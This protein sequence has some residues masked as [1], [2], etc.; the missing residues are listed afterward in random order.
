[1]RNHFIVRYLVI[2]IV[3]SVSFLNVDA[4]SKIDANNL[5]NKLLEKDFK[6]NLPRFQ[7]SIKVNEY[8]KNVS[9]CVETR[10]DS[11]IIYA[12]QAINLAENAGLVQKIAVALQN[13]GQYYMTKEDFTNAISCFINALKI[14]EKRNDQKRIADLIDELATVYYYQEI[15]SKSLKYNENALAVYQKLKDTINIA[16]S[17]SHL[18][19]LHLSHEY[20]EQR[21]VDQK[22]ND[23]KIALK[24]FKQSLRLCEKIGNQN[25]IVHS[26]LNIGNVYNRMDQPEKALDF[27]QKALDFYRESGDSKGIGS[28][29]HTM[30]LIYNKLQMFELALVC[31]TEAVEISN[32]EKLTDGIQFLYEAIAQTYDNLKDYKNA[33]NYY[34]KYMIIRDSIYNNKKSKQIFELETKYQAEKKQREIENLTLV[35]RQRTLVIYIL[36]ASLLIISLLSWMYFRNFRNKKIIADQKLEI[37]EKQL[38]E[39]E[40]ERQLIA[41]KSVLQGEEAERS[42]LAGDLHDGLGGL[43]SGVKLK[44][45][46]MKENAIITIENLAHFNLALELLDTSITEMRR[47]AH[48]LMPETLMHYGLRT[49]LNDFIK[50]V[51]PEGIPIISFNS[52][53][54]DL[55]YNSEME[56]TLYRISQELVTNAIKHANARQIEVQL[57]TEKDRICAQIIDNG[58]G[59]DPEK[60]DPSKTGRGLKNIRD[61]VTAFGGKFEI[62]SQ[63][64]KGTESTIEFLIT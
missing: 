2:L 21:T 1:M 61:R 13:L 34:V 54:E 32:R 55:R 11:A 50:Q 51:E 7:D 19:S 20:C 9:R 46:S 25:R 5:V 44:L 43:L 38:L 58:I 42:R 22:Q 3:C 6:A 57:F 17:L 28:T 33:R 29:L 36:I 18:G 14:E 45:S 39:L 49:A 63:L 37:Q 60:P 27:V 56:I 26:L 59:F 52:F 30:G 10:N 31:I 24:Y 48:N 47:V 35:K 64:G 40:K 16:K 12:D 62:L 41:A 15:F 53:G 23:R 4:Q 8:L